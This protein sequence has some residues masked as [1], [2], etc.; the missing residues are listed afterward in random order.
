M[1]DKLADAGS[2]LLNGAGVFLAEQGLEFGKDL[3]NW[4]KI[5]ALMAFS[6]ICIRSGVE[7]YPF[8]QPVFMYPS[9]ENR[10]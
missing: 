2:S 9:G 3:L 10:D 6:R 1:V 4:V 7:S 5:R 8:V